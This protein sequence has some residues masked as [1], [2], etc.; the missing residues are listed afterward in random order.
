MTPTPPLAELE[1]VVADAKTAALR[2]GR[3]HWV[4]LRAVGP[5]CDPLAHFAEGDAERF[6]WEQPAQDFAIATSG[7]AAVIES[8]G[9]ER[10]PRTIRAIRALTSALHTCGDAAPAARTPLLV[11]GFACTEDG[12]TSALWRGF[13]AARWVLPARSWLCSAGAS[14]CTLIERVDA[15]AQPAQLADALRRRLSEATM[16]AAAEPRA[17]AH[18]RGIRSAAPGFRA[19][20]DGSPERYAARVGEAL[21][22]IAEGSL[23]KVVLARSVRIECDRPFSA[24]A[25]LRA[26]RSSYPSCT[27]FAVG[28]ADA[29]FVGAT[30]ERLLR[31][32]ARQF[33]TSALAGS[34][35]RGHSPE[36]DA[37]LARELIES[38]KEQAEHAVVVRELREILTPICD[39]LQ[40][41]EAP[42]L[43]RLEGIQHLETPF[44]GRLARERH[45]LEL[46]GCLHP[47]A[48]VAGAPRAEALAWLD[49]HEDL[50]RGWYGGCVGF[51]TAEGG[52]ELA[53]AL[54]SALLRGGAA[55]IFAGAGIVAG[56]QPHAELQ[57]TRI[58]LRA[59]LTPLLEI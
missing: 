38:K 31:L 17:A 50:D 15:D 56:S 48:A 25:L 32:D 8:E 28:H 43:L 57:E 22:A 49:E 39:D 9:T 58:K 27:S 54:R 14:W 53:V 2:E 40:V 46:A 52:G 36:H 47:T 41:P 42:A 16:A 7:A 29:S 23:E 13:P 33:A 11:G 20:A 4:A 18:E 19:Q 5:P 44:A 30:P 55:Q 10:W 34:A 6:F 45:L 51:V 26:L 37:D 59:L 21:H 1:C 35:M 3:P 12:G 24:V